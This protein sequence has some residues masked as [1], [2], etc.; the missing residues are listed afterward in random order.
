MLALA[1]AAGLRTVY[2]TLVTPGLPTGFSAGHL[3]GT[4]FS[5][6][7]H[8]DF[9]LP[10]AA[11]GAVRVHGGSRH[12]HSP[13][14]LGLL[15]WAA[16]A[17]LALLARRY[18]RWALAGL[19]L[20]IPTSTI[21]PAADLAADRRMYLPLL[22]FAAAAGIGLARLGL[23]RMRAVAALAA[24]LAIVS[25]FRTGVW[26]NDDRCGA[27]R[28]GAGRRNFVPKIQLAR[29]LPAAQA[30]ELLA[31]AREM[32]PQDP[33][34]AAETGRILLS[35]GQPDAA[36]AEFGR[37]ARAGAARPALSE[38]SRRGAG[39]TG[40]DGGGASGFRAGTE[41][42]SGAGRSA[43]EFGKAGRGGS[44]TVA[45]GGFGGA[46]AGFARRMPGR[47]PA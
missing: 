14:R 2:V 40:T 5:G 20:L 25:F 10:A 4:I 8:R 37:R 47:S 21:F 38:Q 32:A 19:I 16:V 11:G 45:A 12:P 9:A 30:L 29:A 22:A 1:L 34:I 7:R 13:A 36:L 26:M 41:D 44:G 28:C 24:A 39:G 6:G 46:A 17:A 23:D 27:R 35:E 33:A 15:A 42:R 3:A 43:G 31:Q 18:P